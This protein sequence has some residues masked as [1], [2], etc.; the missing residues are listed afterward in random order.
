MH[1]ISFLSYNNKEK[2]KIL[3]FESG[4]ANFS[5]TFCDSNLTQGAILSIS[6]HF[7]ILMYIYTKMLSYN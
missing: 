6:Y 4:F 1:P 7:F 3:R 2:Y 5:I